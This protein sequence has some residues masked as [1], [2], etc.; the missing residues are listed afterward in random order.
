MGLGL[1][2]WD[3]G[4]RGLGVRVLGS[5]L[6]P[7]AKRTCQDMLKTTSGKQQGNLQILYRLRT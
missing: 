6:P 4:L 7:E 1:R 5:V 2:G 3:L